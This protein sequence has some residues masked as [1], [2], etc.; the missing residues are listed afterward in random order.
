MTLSTPSW[1]PPAPDAPLLE[2]TDLVREYTLPREHLLRPPGK[3]QALKGV[4]FSMPSGRSL[5]IVGESGSGKSTLARTVMALD[6]PT[7]G[8]VHLL[9]RNLHQL[10]PAALRQASAGRVLRL[11]HPL[12]PESATAIRVHYAHVAQSKVDA[13]IGADPGGMHVGGGQR[14]AR[15]DDRGKPQPERPVGQ[16]RGAGGQHGLDDSA[17]RRGLRQ[18][19]RT[20]PRW[21]PRRW[22]CGQA[23]AGIAGGATGCVA[24]AVGSVGSMG[25]PWHGLTCSAPSHHTVCARAN[26]CGWCSPAHRL[27]LPP[28]IM[29][30][31]RPGLRRNR[32][33]WRI[34]HTKDPP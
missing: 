32:W 31:P 9:G 22:R 5:G 17:R 3:V 27:P 6:A 11:R 16:A 34:L 24:I 10:A 29:F 2:V 23:V 12:R 30:R 26:T 20:M 25:D 18:G 13:R 1:A 7:S 8:S 19:R 28:E 4:S 21:Q 15:F 14:P 33:R